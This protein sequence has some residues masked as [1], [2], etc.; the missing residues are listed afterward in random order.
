MNFAIIAPNATI[1]VVNAT[2]F[3]QMLEHLSRRSY[4]SCII[5]RDQ[6]FI[7]AELLKIQRF[8]LGK[9]ARYP[10]TSVI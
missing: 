2:I 8:G 9:N 7:C 3:A 10:V 6:C 4:R 1:A 5:I